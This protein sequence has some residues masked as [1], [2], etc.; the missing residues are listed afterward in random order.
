[1]L[2]AMKM[3]QAMLAPFDGIVAELK[4]SV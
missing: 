2:E 4:A 1:M 3:E